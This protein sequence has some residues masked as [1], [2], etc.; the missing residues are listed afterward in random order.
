M[1]FG[2]KLFQEEMNLT[3]DLLID[4]IIRGVHHFK[5]PMNN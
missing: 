5:W 2:N 4:N 1:I 3:T